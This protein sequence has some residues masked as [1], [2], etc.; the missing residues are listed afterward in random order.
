[1]SI[2]DKA[3]DSNGQLSFNI[4]NTDGF[5]G[6]QMTVNWTW[7]P[8]LEVRPRRYR[9]RILNASVSRFFKIALV[10]AAGKRVPFHMIAND[11]NIMEHAV[12]FPNAKSEDLP[13]QGI[14]ERYDIIVDF[15][16][17]AQGTK[18]YM[19][20]LAEHEDGARPKRIAA[21]RRVGGQVGRPRRG[22]VP[23]V[24]RRRLCRRPTRA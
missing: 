18:L 17:F 23:R 14:A 6:D 7:K 5:L 9:F 2:A 3:W 24:P 16:A 21:W 12:R 13:L 11:G 10:N 20:N 1:M 19:V 15:A 22:Q 8:Y 4:F